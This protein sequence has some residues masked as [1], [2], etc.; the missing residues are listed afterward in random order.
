MNSPAFDLTR[1]AAALAE[2]DR[3]D[4]ALTV[5]ALAALPS[6]EAEA[7]LAELERLAREVGLAYGLDTAP[8]NSVET[9][10]RCVRPG[11]F[12]RRMVHLWRERGAQDE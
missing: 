9:C 12:V 6:G 3:A 2:Y 11:E 5:D 7:V 4:A 8:L 1:T 10:E